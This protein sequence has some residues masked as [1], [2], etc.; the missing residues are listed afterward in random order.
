MSFLVISLAGL[1]W[2]K[3]CKTGLSTFQTIAVLAN[4]VTR[5][6]RERKYPDVV[7][8]VGHINVREFSRWICAQQTDTKV[9]ILAKFSRN[10]CQSPILNSS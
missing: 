9:L 7:D 5:Q 4:D 8:N 6:P 1:N 10:S 2:E 3:P